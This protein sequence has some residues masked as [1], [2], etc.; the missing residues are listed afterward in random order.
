MPARPRRQRW[1]QQ[2]SDQ[3]S[4]DQYDGA[5][6]QHDCHRDGKH[7]DCEDRDQ[8]RPERA[9]VKVLERVDVADEAAQNVAAANPAQSFRHERD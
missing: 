3:H 7:R 4:R 9:Q 2:T 8:R 6:G 5:G 1:Q